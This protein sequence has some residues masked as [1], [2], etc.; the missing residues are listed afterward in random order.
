MKSPGPG[1]SPGPGTAHHEVPAVAP[2]AEEI[3]LPFGNHG[4][5]L[6]IFPAQELDRDRIVRREPSRQLDEPEP[7]ERLPARSIVRLPA[8]QHR[9]PI[10]LGDDVAERMPAFA[11]GPLGVTAST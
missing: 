7:R 2:L 4:D 10:E 11:A 3:G 6:S 8:A 1:P 5:G 9:L